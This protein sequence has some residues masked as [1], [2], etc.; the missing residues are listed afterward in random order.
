MTQSSL[1][2]AKLLLGFIALAFCAAP[3]PG[4]VGGCG[5][6]A[7]ELDP[8]TFFWS[9]QSY[10]CEHCRDCDLHSKACDRACGEQLVQAEFPKNCS[11]LVHDGEVCLRALDNASCDDFAGYMSDTDPSIPTECN[12]C[13]PGKQP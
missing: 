9:E 5:Q 8:Q 12:F 13:P 2:L 7:Q 3:V 1:R 6:D 4:D 11:P 10:E